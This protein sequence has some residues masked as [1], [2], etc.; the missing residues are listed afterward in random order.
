MGAGLWSCSRCVCDVGSGPNPSLTP[1]QCPIL[2]SSGTPDPQQ[3]AWI[4]SRVLG[5][6]ICTLTASR[7]ALTSST[8][9]ISNLPNG[10]HHALV[11]HLSS[12][13]YPTSALQA[14]VELVTAYISNRIGGSMGAVSDGA[15]ADDWGVK[16][17]SRVAA[18][19][20]ASLPFAKDTLELTEVF[21]AVAS[22][23]QRPRLELAA[24]YSTI[25]DSLGPAEMIS[26]FTTWEARSGYGSSPPFIHL[27]DVQYTDA[28]PFASIP[29]SC[30]SGSRSTFSHTTERAKWSVLIL[31]L[32]GG[33]RLILSTNRRRKRAKP[34]G[35]R[36]TTASWSTQSS[37]FKFGE[38]SSYTTPC[39]RCVSAKGT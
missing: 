26:S 24:F 7:F 30:R 20:C 35:R 9:S 23:Q 22:N 38:R 37:F 5:L 6:Y 13:S 18:L 29:F 28:S 27:T 10:L 17:G 36:S 14:K 19:L 15:Y 25:I 1:S 21:R 33:L 39:D 34:S 31:P 8:H 12:P 4:L 2:L 16:T 11:Q 32:S 3:R